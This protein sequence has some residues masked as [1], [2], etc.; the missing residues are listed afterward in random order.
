M[1]KGLAGVTVPTIALIVP[2]GDPV[3]RPQQRRPGRL[4]RHAERGPHHGLQ[5]HL[6]VVVIPWC[7]LWDDGAT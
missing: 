4:V 7:I 2:D 6:L 5:R 1:D 3:H